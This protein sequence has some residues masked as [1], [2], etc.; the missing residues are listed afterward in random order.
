[1]FHVF[2][3]VI[4]LLGTPV[5]TAVSVDEFPNE[6]A[7]RVAAPKY[8]IDLQTAFDTSPDPNVKGQFA[9]AEAI[10]AV[11]DANGNPTKPSGA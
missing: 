6:D 8:L 3:L 4:S 10:C 5:G 2:V 9:A 1:M 11:P 7:C